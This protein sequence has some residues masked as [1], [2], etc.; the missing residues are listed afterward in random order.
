MAET[1]TNPNEILS[2]SERV[3]IRAEV[4]YALIAAKESREPEPPKTGLSRILGYLSNGFVLLIVGSIITSILV[5]HFQ[6]KY[7]RRAQQVTL[8]QECLS[9]FLLY[10]NSLWQEYYALLPLTQKSEIDEATYLGYV[11]K[12]A[13]I[14][15]KRYDAYAKV[16]A[17]TV[18]FEL[19]NGASTEQPLN[20]TLKRY[21]IDLN[22]ASAAM[23]KW[24]TGLYC[25]PFTRDVS[26]CEEFDPSFDPYQE[27]LKIKSL[28]SSVGNA[29]TDAV[30]AEIVKRISQR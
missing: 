9:Q 2:E 10:S 7:E 30:A 19:E 28:V 24:L 12:V 20:S 1:P 6:K 16:Q 29:G 25:T 4:R 23:D 13:E 5:P 21:A 17:L 22:L 11:N 14:K 18:V 26:P 3:K 15:L 27:H 8:M